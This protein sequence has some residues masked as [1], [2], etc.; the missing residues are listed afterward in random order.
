MKIITEKIIPLILLSLSVFLLFSEY[1]RE[2]VGLFTTIKYFGKSEISGPI[3]K[4]LVA[5]EKIIGA[6]VASDNNL[7]TIAI[8]FNTYWRI[9]DDWVMFRLRNYES[10]TWYYQNKY[11]VD[12]F[13]NEKMFPFGFPEIPDSAGEKYVFELESVQGGLNNAVAISSKDPVFQVRYRFP[14]E[15]LF[16][17]QDM[18]N[19]TISKIVKYNLFTIVDYLNQKLAVNF[20]D[21]SKASITLTYFIPVFC[22]LFGYRKKLRKLLT[23]IIFFTLLDS[24]LVYEIYDKSTIILF[25]SWIW[26][27]LLAKPKTIY[28][29]EIGILLLA[30]SAMTYYVPELEIISQKIGSW[31]LIFLIFSLGKKINEPHW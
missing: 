18:N 16:N 31:S 11:K 3:N 21:M 25:F 20:S 8:R 1:E 24:F 30:L 19:A 2:K 27:L 9:N 23:L 26:Y 5:G 17:F 28:L 13:Q 15:T 4:E 10:D 7:G 6:F 22:Y 12:Q 29:S 14:K